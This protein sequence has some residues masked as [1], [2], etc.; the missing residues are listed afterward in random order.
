MLPASP[1][2]VSLLDGNVSHPRRL[3]LLTYL[4]ASAFG[5]GPGSGCFVSGA[6]GV[7][8]A[9]PTTVLCTDSLHLWP[10]LSVPLDPHSPRSYHLI[11]DLCLGSDVRHP[12]C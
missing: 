6:M 12:S 10:E 5:V 7:P 11:P 3:D 2:T 4:R 9:P 1:P 8:V